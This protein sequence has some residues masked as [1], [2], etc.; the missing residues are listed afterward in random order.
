MF[1]AAYQRDKTTR[2]WRLTRT[3]DEDE[4]I[5]NDAKLKLRREYQ[6]RLTFPNQLKDQNVINNFWS[7]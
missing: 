7:E 5:Q 1:K 4:L 6:A 2:L 3:P